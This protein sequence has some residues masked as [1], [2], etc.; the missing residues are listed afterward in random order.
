MKVFVGGL[1]WGVDSVRLKHVFSE[2]GPIEEATVVHD[3]VTGKSRGFGFVTFS[4]EVDGETV[5]SIGSIEVDGRMVRID[6]ASEKK[7]ETRFE[8]K[9][10]GRDRER[11]RDRH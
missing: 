1:P 11:G 4:D 8:E 9:R 6:H 3:K 2:F 5:L 10:D 7:L